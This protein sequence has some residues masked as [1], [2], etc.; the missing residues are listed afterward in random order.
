MPEADSVDEKPMSDV[1]RGRHDAEAKRHGIH[2]KTAHKLHYDYCLPLRAELESSNAKYQ[3]NM[4]ILYSA[5]E[6]DGCHASHSLDRDLAWEHVPRLLYEN[7]IAAPSVNKKADGS[8]ETTFLLEP[9]LEEVPSDGAAADGRTDRRP[10]FPRT[11]GKVYRLHNGKRPI[12]FAV[13]PTAAPE[14]VTRGK[15]LVPVRVGD[16][17]NGRGLP[18][19]RRPDAAAWDVARHGGV[20]AAQLDVDLGADC[21]ISHVATQGRPPPT[22]VYPRVR[23]E[24]RRIRADLLGARHNHNSGLGRRA[25]RTALAQRHEELGEGES[26]DCY[27]VEGRRWDLLKHGQYSGPF[28]DVLDLKGDEE[29]CR[30]TGRPYT[31]AERWLQWVG[32]YEL[33]YRVAGG[34]HWYSLGIFKG[35]VD[36]T[37]EAVHD[38][39][40]LRARYLRWVP[41]EVEGLGALR[42]GVYGMTSA[43]AALVG[44][45]AGAESGEEAPDPIRYTLRTLGDSVNIKYS[46]CEK[47]TYTN[48]KDWYKY[49][50]R[51]QLAVRRL[52]AWIE[53]EQQGGATSGEE[54]E[55]EDEDEDE[56]A[57]AAHSPPE[58][59]H[60]GAWV[61]PLLRPLNRVDSWR[62][63]PSSTLDDDEAWSQC[64]RSERCSE[65]E[66]SETAWSEGAWS[67]LSEAEQWLQVEAFA[68]D[69]KQ[70]V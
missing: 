63:P 4:R 44:S 38:V 50:G 56:E 53:D 10:G 34:R 32:R 26:G 12:L 40:G 9:L 1:K 29:R 23:R 11:D 28:W 8:I 70:R 14:A 13:P 24:R 17:R 47:H 55:N 36:V 61:E 41:L 43:A 33:K 21:D 16:C 3:P 2:G 59:P 54:D 60:V 42:V 49:P 48:G 22:R 6:L 37:G 31:P 15:L 69:T 57:A 30:R 20:G 46:Y 18:L 68:R 19:V 5:L 45:A 58:R 66:W 64:A 62:C 35:N 39:R 27:W 51:K 52:N 65:S 67:E 25:Q 7:S